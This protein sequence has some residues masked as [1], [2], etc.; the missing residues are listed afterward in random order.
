MNNGMT[1]FSPADLSEQAARCGRALAEFDRKETVWDASEL[2]D[3]LRHQLAAPVEFGPLE[4]P[5]PTGPAPPASASAP[6]PVTP[7][8]IR[9]FGELLTQPEPPLALLVQLK[10]FAKVNRN[11]P[12]SVLPEP[13]CAVLYYAAIAAARLRL[14]AEITQMAPADV[15]AGFAWCLRL[16]WLDAATRQLLTDAAAGGA[17]KAD[18]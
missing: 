3:V 10:E 9:S 1:S 12:Q 14:G 13:L 17:S 18:R 4:S 16:E 8:G 7:A 15:Q 5:P 11:H 6:A 2:G